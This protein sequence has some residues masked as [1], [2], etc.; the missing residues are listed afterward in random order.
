M[1]IVDEIIVHCSATRPEWFEGK[2]I[3]QKRDEIRNWHVRDR[4]WKDIGY[5]LLIDRDGKTAKGR[6]LDKDGDVWEEIGAHV[7]GKNTRS[8]GLCLIGGFGANANDPFEKNFTKAQDDTLR[9][10]IADLQRQF[11]SI[12]KVSGHNQY[13][14]K[15][16]PGFKVVD[17]LGK[18]KS[19]VAVVDYVTKAPKKDN[20]ITWFINK[21]GELIKN[22]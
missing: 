6:D 19:P 18:K 15:A 14:A 3:N 12:K 8:I 17:W 2:T 16:C 13:A 1:R 7:E 20:F 11:P 4:G 22:P 9:M 10:V 5:A 21:L